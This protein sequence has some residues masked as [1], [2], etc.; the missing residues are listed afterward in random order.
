[1]PE[2]TPPGRRAGPPG[3]R[4]ARGRPRRDRPAERASSCRRSSPS[5]AR[6]ASASSRS[7]RAPGG[8]GC[9]ARP[10]A[11][12]P[13]AGRAAAE[14]DRPRRRQRTPRMPV[15][16]LTPVG[17][18]RDGR[19]H[20]GRDG[21][22]RRRQPPG[23]GDVAG[24]RHLPAAAGGP[25]RDRGPRRRP[26]RRRRHARASPRRSW[27]RS[28]GVV[29]ASLAEAGD[30][31]EYGQELVVIELALRAAAPADGLS[32]VP[33]DP[34]RQSRRDRAPHPARLPDARRRGRRRLQ[35]GRS[36]L[37]P[38]PARRR[39][40]LHRAGR[41]AALVP[42]GAGR[43]LGRPRHR[44]RRDPPGL[45]VPVRGRGLR[46]GRRRPRPDVHRAA[47]AASSSGSPARRARAAC[48]A[49]HGLPTIPGSDGMLRDEMHALDEAERIG[50]PVLI[51]PSA[52]GGGKGMRMVRTPRELESVAQ[53]LP[54]GGEGGVRRRLA[55]PREVARREP[56][57][58]DP[59]RGRPL[60][61]TASTSASA[62]ARSS[63]AT[64]RS[65]R[66]R[67]PRRSPTAAR[68]DLAER[69]IRAVVAAGYENVGTLEF[70][71]DGD[72]QRLLHRDQLPHPGRAPGHRDADRHRPRRDP[73][74][75]RGRRAARLQ[76]GGRHASAAT[77]S[78][79]GSTPRTRPHD[80]RPG[81]GHRRA[82]P[83]AGRPGRPHG[84]APVHRAT[85]SRRSTTRCSASSSSGART[86]RPRSPAAGS[87]STSSSS[88]ASSPTSRSTGRC[89]PTRRSSRAG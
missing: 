61:R 3:R 86:A 39:G 41:R 68:A 11:T 46:R 4:R 48:S 77:P 70:L 72:G 24:R 43:H 53:G 13:R 73:D 69:A 25:C 28:T 87:R 31:V 34:H 44:L 10:A 23:R 89:W 67:R 55:V 64:R 84:L 33:Q 57:R 9:V 79:S 27:R 12:A 42:L 51:K 15:G 56:P 1:M 49:T 21:A 47:R 59:G 26:A 80:F 54:L 17:P 37:A 50:Y 81:A 88:T 5:S 75:D 45:R 85:R 14:R 29:G 83:R 22:R 36:R 7:A 8:S 62:T 58:R 35:R 16:E 82:L 6:P 76:P 78:S 65:S 32:R 63:A 30:A 19:G 74:P 2:P 20:D 52:G 40:D 66:R 71:V 60:R 38:G 18:G